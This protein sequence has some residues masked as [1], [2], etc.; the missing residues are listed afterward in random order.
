MG[1][2]DAGG[3]T[4]NICVVLR[5]QLGALFECEQ[6][7]ERVQIRT[8][9]IFPDGDLIDLY[10]RE[11]PQGQVV[12]DLGDTRGWL[13]ISGGNAQLTRRQ[14]QAYDDA[15][16]TYDIERLDSV[17]LARVADG[18]LADAV[19]RLVQAITAVSQVLDLKPAQE[20]VKTSAR[21]ITVKRITTTLQKYR[22]H[23][24]R[25]Q[26][27]CQMA[28]WSNQDWKLDFM[29]RT[30]EQDAALFALHGRKHTGWQW[31]AIEH[32]FTAFSDLVPTLNEMHK[33]TRAVSVIDDLDV[34]W[35]DEPIEL[36]NSVSAVVRLSDPESL[37]QAIA[38]RW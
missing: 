10:W 28:G 18:N 16:S 23:G 4:P 15:C 9:F 5:S 32:A 36:L 14:L 33:P 8:P 25:Y 7:G 22:G 21:Q 19:V 1:I 31:R 3:I 34:H 27:N 37:P 11:T 17:L 24:W 35:D 38:G 30:P 26:E 12:S 6:A 20:T 2:A 29:V 13:F